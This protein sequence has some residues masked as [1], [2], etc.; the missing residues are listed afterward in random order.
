MNIYFLR[1]LKTKGNFEK[2]YIGRT[3]ESL[4]DIEKQN[5][6]KELPKNPDVIFVSP[7]KRCVETA[8]L[9]YK[10]FQII[11]N[12]KEI[13]FGEF[14][15]K[16]YEDL[17]DNM[18]YR[19]FIDGTEEALGGELRADF[20]KRCLDAFYEIT[21]SANENFTIVIVCHGGTIMSIMDILECS[22]K[23]FYGY[24]ISNGDY[25]K[26]KYKD[27]ILSIIEN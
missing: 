22:K 25:I 13:D 24:Q 1:H 19:N 10:D 23:G 17:K 11:D 8:S 5:I 3:D 20:N 9:F 18:H 27:K 26:C 6:T 2:R 4:V 7:M 12:L 15:N 21:E 16:T 14:E